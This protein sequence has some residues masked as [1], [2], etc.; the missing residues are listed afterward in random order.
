MEAA[1]RSVLVV[2]DDP[3]ARRLLDI[4]LRG[5]G[6]SVL[7]AGDGEEALDVI[8][9]ESPALVLLDLQMPGMGGMEVLRR[10]RKDGNDVP[11]IV[12]TAH[13]SIEI[14]V[15]AIKEG[16]TDFLL[17]PVD[18]AHLD[19]VVRKAL[20]RRD[21]VESNRLLR[22]ALA[23]RMPG[24][25]GGSRAMRAAIEAARKAAATASTVLLLGESG[26]GKE[27]FAHAVHG[28]S[29][30]SEKPFIVVNCVAL[31]EHLLESELFGHERGAFTGAHQAKKGKF[32]LANGGTVFL[33]EIG[34]M[35][36]D[37]QA[38]LLRVLQDH[39]F[40]RVGG[41]RP[42]EADI[43]VIAATN[44]NLDEAV[45]K[46]R[47][48]EDLFYRLNVIRIVLPPLRDRTDDLPDLV[49]HFVARYAAE[50]KRP[51]PSVSTDAMALLREHAWP[52]N[53][54]ELAN[55]IERAVVLCGGR[56]IRAKDLALPVTVA[57]GE[58]DRGGFTCSDTSNF[59]DLLK[60]YKRAVIQD[61]LRKCG[62]NQTQ[63]AR[64][65]GLQRTY[66]SK[67]VR[68]LGITVSAAAEDERD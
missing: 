64:R 3:A 59:H 36:A 1:G 23:A 39:Q 33:D 8:E 9:R 4:R 56:E 46:G 51:P 28:W 35:P 20:E 5:L 58:A 68:D 61:A 29:P 54:R 47:F 30:R 41:T 66:L 26:T 52:G 34:D 2:D 62:G 50:T 14:A 38:K 40:E 43:R 25:V 55:T 31:S 42:I 57:H 10:L 17:K 53:V 45:R 18:G 44:R 12:I 67:L 32:E 48:R 60:E 16:A 21:L 65:L 6:C 63:T 7:S 27:V 49:R 22:E 37:L 11:A 15:E 13:G 24:I 19:I